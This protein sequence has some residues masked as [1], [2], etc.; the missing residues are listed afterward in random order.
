MAKCA[1]CN[2]KIEKTFLNKI[3]GTYVK[4]KTVCSKCQRKSGKDL[5]D[6]I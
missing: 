6:K 1:I 3:K 2:E 5:K 4:G